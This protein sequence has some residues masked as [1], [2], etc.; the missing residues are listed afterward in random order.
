MR[1]LD[2]FSQYIKKS[3]SNSKR[4][5]RNTCF[6]FIVEFQFRWTSQSSLYYR[7][8][9]LLAWFEH[10]M[11]RF[12]FVRRWKWSKWKGEQLFSLGM[13]FSFEILSRLTFKNIEWNIVRDNYSNLDPFHNINMQAG[14]SNQVERV[15]GLYER[16]QTRVLS[17][18]DEKP[19]LPH[20]VIVPNFQRV[21]LNSQTKIPMCWHMN[22]VTYRTNI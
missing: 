4:I 21:F 11:R 14:V 3:L 18:I 12:L 1:W 19:E 20:T 9:L 6:C 13:T 22:K 17:E 2:S 8:A 10:S 16:K 15:P 5:E 7:R